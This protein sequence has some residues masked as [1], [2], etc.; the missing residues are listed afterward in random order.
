MGDEGLVIEDLFLRAAQIGLRACHPE[1][2]GMKDHFAP[3][4]GMGE[5]FHEPL[6]GEGEE[7]VEPGV[8]EVL[9]ARGLFVEKVAEGAFPRDILAPDD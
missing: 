6:E 1:E 9:I 5:I 3:P 4:D 8:H 2:V 7:S